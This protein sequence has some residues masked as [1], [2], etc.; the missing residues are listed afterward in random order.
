MLFFYL[1]VI[2]LISVP[3]NVN[4]QSNSDSL[5]KYSYSIMGFSS[6]GNFGVPYSGTAFFIRNG[7]SVFLITAKHV[8]SGCD[9]GNRKM[10]FFPDVM[11]V[12]VLDRNDS[13]G[14]VINVNIEKIKDSIVCHESFLD[15]DF[16]ALKIIVHDTILK[17]INS[18]ENLIMPPFEEVEKIAMFGFPLNSIRNPSVQFGFWMPSFF[19][20]NGVETIISGAFTDTVS[21]RTDSTNYYFYNQVA[22]IDSSLKG[23]SGSPVFVKDRSSDRW[24]ITGLFAKF[25]YNNTTGDK[26]ITVPRIDYILRDIHRD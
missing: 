23:F 12:M 19:E 5:S 2:F 7:S 22:K 17:K 11:N 13:S 21:N 18:V 10:P 15:S 6:K 25:G 20:L 16:I 26:F 14:G 1:G 24:R 8:L 9:D 3:K 4:S